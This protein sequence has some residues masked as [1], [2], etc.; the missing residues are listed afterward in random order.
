[1][2]PAYPRP[3]ASTPRGDGPG[4]VRSYD[5]LVAAGP[6]QVKDLH[7]VRARRTEPARL[8]GVEV[9]R[10]AEARW[11]GQ[12]FFAAGFFAAV[13]LPEAVTLSPVAFG[14]AAR[15]TPARSASMRST[16]PVGSAPQQVLP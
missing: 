8:T 15:S 14:L 2:E 5:G 6:E 16:T 4:G 12:I 13:V 1:M 11:G 3:A 9:G 7:G 10:L